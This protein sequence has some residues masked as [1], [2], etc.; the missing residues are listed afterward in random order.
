[1]SIAELMVETVLNKEKER[2]PNHESGL[3][4]FSKNAPEKLSP[5][6]FNIGFFFYFQY[7]VTFHFAKRLLQ[8][9]YNL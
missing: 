9:D 1:M 6:E 4:S 8:R 5:L 2:M 3:L 7:H